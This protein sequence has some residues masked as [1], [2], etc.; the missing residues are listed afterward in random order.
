[1]KMICSNAAMCGRDGCLHIKPHEHMSNCK[2]HCG[3]GIEGD[4][5]CVPHN[6][7]QDDEDYEKALKLL[8]LLAP[9]LRP[10]SEGMY[11]TA[12]REKSVVGVYRLIRDNV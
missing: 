12:N 8:A 3:R 2:S 4:T 7:I 11:S 5:T 10:N 9:A 6:R 1:M